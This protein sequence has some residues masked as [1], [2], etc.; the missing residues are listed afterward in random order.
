MEKVKQ[1]IPRIAILLAGVFVGVVIQQSCSQQT[2]IGSEFE[3]S[4][5][6]ENLSNYE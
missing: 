2:T 5:F 3:D 4:E 1:L 6:I